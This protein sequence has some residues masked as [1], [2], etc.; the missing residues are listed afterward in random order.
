[1]SGSDVKLLHSGGTVRIVMPAKV[2]NALKSLQN[3]LTGIAAKLGCQTCFSGR[4]CAFAT[5]ISH[6]GGSNPASE[7]NAAAAPAL[8]AGGG[9]E[10][11]A[12]ISSQ[13]AG[14]IDLVKKAI[15][16]IAGRLGCPGC[17]SGFDLNLRHELEVIQINEQGSIV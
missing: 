1:M 8:L 7:A 9:R 10:I 12:L 16:E 3:S 2:A 14:K 6:V 13:T 17:C 5:A 11:T 4:D 15:G